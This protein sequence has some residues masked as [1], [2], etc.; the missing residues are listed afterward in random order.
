MDKDKRLELLKNNPALIDIDF[1][2]D[3]IIRG[4]LERFK[5]EYSTLQWAD[6]KETNT[7]KRV[8]IKSQEF[9]CIFAGPRVI[10]TT[11]G[12]E[13]YHTVP[14]M[15]AFFYALL[16]R[17]PSFDRKN[18]ASEKLWEIIDKNILP[19]CEET[20]GLY[21]AIMKIIDFHKIDMIDNNLMLDVLNQ[22]NDDSSLYCNMTVFTEYVH[23][24][25]IG[26]LLNH[27]LDIKYRTQ[28]IYSEIIKGLRPDR[29]LGISSED[30]VAFFT[31][32]S[33]DI[34]LKNF[35]VDMLAINIFIDLFKIKNIDEF[36]ALQMK[37]IECRYKFLNSSVNDTKGPPAMYEFDN[38][39][40]SDGLI[41]HYDNLK[42]IF[43]RLMLLT[44]KSGK[45]GL[46]YHVIAYILTHAPLPSYFVYSSY[47]KLCTF[48]LNICEKDL[49]GVK[50]IK[51]IIKL[52]PNI[53]IPLRLIDTMFGEDEIDDIIEGL[54]LGFAR[55]AFY[56]TDRFN[57]YFTSSQCI[58]EDTHVDKYL[59]DSLF[60][61]RVDFII[62][63]VERNVVTEED[64]KDG[65]DTLHESTLYNEFDFEETL[66]RTNKYIADL[67]DM[68]QR[69]ENDSL[70]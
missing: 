62:H 60:L 4:F 31:T 8:K 55:F 1:D 22:I 9:A 19:Y 3:T 48:I 24:D 68:K 13:C 26:Q 47:E 36:I 21:D 45:F 10:T 35:D 61:D 50:N 16:S 11:E 25:S 52:A 34:I 32:Q 46:S 7:N 18:D 28:I 42:K 56:A 6:E 58:T 69:K 2:Y 17:V 30:I 70:R 65:R 49:T 38:L 39:K 53:D 33:D 14:D 67:K 63:E 37:N 57:S 29:L 23:L 66:N 20:N 12:L 15:L 5:K 64:K 51:K 40:M 59:S 43:D 41:I 44:T 27:S 54:R